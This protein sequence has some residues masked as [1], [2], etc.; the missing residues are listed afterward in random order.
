MTSKSDMVRSS[1]PGTLAGRV[2][3]VTGGGNGIGAAT[4][5]KFASEGAAVVVNDLDCELAEGLVEEIVEAGGK[6][7]ACVGDVTAADFAERCV[8]TAIEELGGLDI[9]VNNAGYARHGMLQN[10]GDDIWDAMIAV[11]LTAPFR[12]LRAAVPHFRDSARSER[13]LG[14]SRQRKVVNV[15]SGSIKGVMGHSGYASG[16]AGLLG[17][18]TTA[19][20]ELGPFGVNVN[21]VAFGLIETRINAP[22]AEGEDRNA[23]IAGAA[24]R[25]GMPA[26]RFQQVASGNMLGRAGTPEEAAGAIYLLCLPESDF[27]TGQCLWVAG[28]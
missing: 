5:R 11:H 16:K 3:I 6:A 2:A 24:I 13:E 20:R 22:L 9:V 23:E 1:R 19:A 12:L 8:R 17:L 26:D 18:T 25:M 15:S 14:Q 21:A 7:A 4:V 10:T 27:I 28:G